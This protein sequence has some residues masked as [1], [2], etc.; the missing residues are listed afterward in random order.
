ML[1]LLA[2]SISGMSHYIDG[3]RSLRSHIKNRVRRLTRAKKIDVR[4]CDILIL[5][6][7]VL[8]ITDSHGRFHGKEKEVKHYLGFSALTMESLDLPL[9]KEKEP[10]TFISVRGLRLSSI[11]QNVDIIDLDGHYSDST[12]ELRNVMEEISVAIDQYNKNRETFKNTTSRIQ[13][14]S[15]PVSSRNLN[16]LGERAPR[17]LCQN[18]VSMCS[19]CW[20][21]FSSF[22]SKHHCMA[23]GNIICSNCASNTLSL[24]YRYSKPSLQ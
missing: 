22:S 13:L 1:A 2:K 24:K 18:D 11:E 7:S 14:K 10:H 12:S 17:L 23:C 4:P 9:P 6:D 20:K 16:E 15:S 8:V 19:Y 21:A 3:R 5:T